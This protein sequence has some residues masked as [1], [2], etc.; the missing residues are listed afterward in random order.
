M[1]NGKKKSPQPLGL[2]GLPEGKAQDYAKSYHGRFAEQI[3]ELIKDTRGGVFFLNGT[4]GQGKTAILDLIRWKIEETSS[5]DPGEPRRQCI[6]IDPVDLLPST[7][8][9]AQLESVLIGAMLL[10]AAEDAKREA[11]NEY[12]ELLVHGL[13]LVQT[14]EEV[15]QRAIAFAADE[16]EFV[17]MMKNLVV[18]AEQVGKLK[19]PCKNLI[20]LIDDVDVRPALTVPTLR[21][22]QFLARFAPVVVCGDEAE[23][24]KQLEKDTRS[25]DLDGLLRSLLATTLDVPRFSRS[26]QVAFFAIPRNRDDDPRDIWARWLLANNGG[27][28]YLV[29]DALAGVDVGTEKGKAQDAKIRTYRL[30]MDE[31]WSP[32]DLNEDLQKFVKFVASHLM[33]ESGRDL[34]RTT[35]ELVWREKSYTNRT[36]P[37]DFLAGSSIDRAQAQRMVLG[38]HLLVSRLGASEYKPL[39][40][41]RVWRVVELLGSEA[42][43]ELTHE[44]LEKRSQ[45]LTGAD[46]DTRAALGLLEQLAAAYDRKEDNKTTENGK[47]QP[48]PLRPEERVLWEFLR[49][50]FFKWVKEGLAPTKM[51]DS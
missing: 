36:L 45:A 29:A 32:S 42:M 12:R 34:A 47:P 17:K 48:K 35:N 49:D 40:A 3:V 1:T 46:S 9:Q 19:E 28:A 22:A 7:G 33:P 4:R 30:V 14:R 25:S 31:D 21:A 16:D 18:G 51:A 37:F 13:R 26:R 41:G 43:S 39:L 6:S 2:H 23:V 20:F 44:E 10:K 38:H 24:R 15:V 5:N 8:G 50:Y 11:A 27:K